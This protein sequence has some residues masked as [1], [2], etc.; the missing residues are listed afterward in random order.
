MKLRSAS[1]VVPVL[2]ALGCGS[3][4]VRDEL[5]TLEQE[6]VVCAKGETVEGIDVSYYQGTID[7]DAVKASGRVFAIARI[8]D[9][10]YLDTKFD[11]N[12][13]AMKKVGLIRG[14]YQFFRPGQNPDTLADIVISKVGKLGD[15]DLPVTIDVEATD[16]QSAATII[17]KM[18]TWIAKVEAGTGKKPI[19]YTGKYFW[20]DNVANSK[21][22]T[23]YPL[24]IAAYGPTCPNL[25]DGAWSTWTFFQYTDRSSV[26]GISGGVDGDKF[27]GPLADLQKLAGGGPDYAAQFVSQSWPFATT[28]FP[29]VPGQE[30]DAYIELKNVGRKAWDS[31]T[32]LATTVE[33]DRKSVFAGAS[34]LGGNR[35]AAVT[36]TVPPGG[37]FKFQFKWHAPTTTGNFDEHFGLVQDGVAWFGDG[38]QGGPADNVIEAKIDVVS[39]KYAAQLVSQS[40]PS[41]GEVLTMKVGE[42]INGF[43]ELRN[44]GTEPWRAGQTK[45]APTP[46]E[47]AS[48]LAAGDWLSPTR[49]ATP[50][51]DVAPGGTYRFPVSLRAASAGDF[52]QTFGVVEEGVT[53][54][55]DAPN[56]GGP[57]DDVLAVHVSATSAITPAG[58][59]AVVEARAE[60]DIN[61]SCGCSVPGRREERG[62]FSLV[63]LLGAMA[64]RRQKE[65]RRLD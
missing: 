46:R 30:L 38:D 27:N 35:L 58:D 63:A 61:G 49:V 31:N 18:K 11:A 12:W 40:F 16:G 59:D 62:G 26:P 42:T 2:L 55:S 54:F 65:K 17:S 20:Q 60:G 57:R 44:I 5:G 48:P 7:W 64:L 22:F 19:I 53:W 6:V 41:G 56:G 25:P 34:W 1:L 3:P 52:V 43:I 4:G 14:A 51:T 9:G 10:T 45:L 36:G 37:T 24:W 28:S 47:T 33:R 39:A 15:G 13:P 29:M 23:S 21:E 32:K 8:S 50:S